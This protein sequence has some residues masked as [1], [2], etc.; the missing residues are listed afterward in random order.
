MLSE[1]LKVI[2][3]LDAS[4]VVSIDIAYTSGMES[5]VV[6]AMGKHTRAAITHS[7]GRGVDPRRAHVHLK[8]TPDSD[9]WVVTVVIART[10][11]SSDAGTGRFGIA[12]RFVLTPSGWAQ[13]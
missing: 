11:M 6:A 7:Q 12:G 5:A 2:E 13:P 8:I 3:G 9:A 10:A 4:A 1:V